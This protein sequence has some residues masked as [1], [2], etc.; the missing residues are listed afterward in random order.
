MRLLIV[1]NDL[2]VYAA[3]ISQPTGIQ[4]VGSGLSEALLRSDIARPALIAV[5][6]DGAREIE[7]RSLGFANDAP[8]RSARLAAPLLALLAHAP[9]ALQ[10]AVRAKA[11]GML[12]T[13]AATSGNPIDVAPGD[14]IAVIG[15][16]WIA[17]GTA[18][19]TIEIKRRS[20]ARLAIL[21]HD[22]F[23]LT[24]SEWYADG[25]AAE[26]RDDVAA[27]VNEADRIYS[28]SSDVAAAVRKRFDR[29]VLVLTPADP[30][31]WQNDARQHPDQ[32]APRPLRRAI[33]EPEVQ[34]P[35]ILCVGTLHPRKNLA[36]LVHALSQIASSR[37]AESTPQLVIVGRRHPQDAALFEALE[38]CRSIPRL[39][40]RIILI[41]DAN[42]ERLARLYAASRFVVV[43][44]LAEG[45][46]IP[47]REA[48]VAGRPVIATDAVPAA[49][50]SPFIRVVP[51]GNEEA[52]T[53]A[54]DEWW[55]GDEPEMLADQIA[56]SFIPRTWG[57]VAREFVGGLQ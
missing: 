54:I 6:T 12:A 26:A 52:L 50:G 9:R 14:W 17:P 43:P 42:D 22:L 45:W 10:E 4:R 5:G 27:L 20:R 57:D 49:M 25:Q 44:S 19:A 41:H 40:Q 46:G 11:R 15:A 35:Y 38:A 31:L 55:S 53:T 8:R 32:N 16:P 48:L 47:A 24:A 3:A 33:A 21:V 51:A 2:L 29:E 1:V 34:G 30:V 37:G 13:R 23:P 7:P 36:A 56:A 28:V 18:N 39:R